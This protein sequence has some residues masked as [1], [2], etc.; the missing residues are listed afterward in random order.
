MPIPSSAQHNSH[1]SPD[2]H[3]QMEPRE[4]AQVRDQATLGVAV[5]EDAAIFREILAEAIEKHPLLSLTAM[6]GSQG[7]AVNTI[8]WAA[9]TL[10]TID[11]HL[12][13]GI[14]IDLARKVR[15]TYP[16][17]RVCLLSDHRRPPLIDEL[18]EPERDYWSYVLKSSIDGRAHL[19]D[20]LFTAAT[21]AFIDPRV[22]E[23]VTP[24]EEAVETLTVQQREILACV[25]QGMSNAAIARKLASS[26]KSV[27]YHLT[28]IYQRLGILGDK[29][30][31]AR[32]TSAVMYLQRYAP[33]TRTAQ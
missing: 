31:N 17:V 3:A 8:P 13:D 25:A 9:T 24:T 18:P 23:A 4:N 32:V 7:E 2:Q 19:G 16:H 10:V 1:V 20:L 26:E 14:G 11:L 27:E 15:S 5:V 12:P 21:Q 6:A 28:Q 30:A 22:M 33:S 29:D